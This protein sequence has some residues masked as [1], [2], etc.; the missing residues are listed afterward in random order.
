MGKNTNL[1]KKNEIIIKI[2]VIFLVFNFL[3]FFANIISLVKPNVVSKKVVI[4][5]IKTKTYED[6]VSDRDVTEN[7]MV[8]LDDKNKEYY[9]VGH[10]AKVGNTINIYLNAKNKNIDSPYTKWY[11]NKDSIVNETKL[12]VLLTFI[13]VVGNMVILI[14]FSSE[15][16]TKG[17]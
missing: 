14:G 7:Y 6:S 1:M 5:E 16:K 3:I 2:L 9:I 12:G 17:R 11:V 8:G 4:S 13:L 10:N 15:V